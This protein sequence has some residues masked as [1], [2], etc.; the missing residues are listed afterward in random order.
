MVQK[1]S[2]MSKICLPILY[3]DSYTIFGDFCPKPF[4]L[5]LFLIPTF[6]C[7]ISNASGFGSTKSPVQFFFNSKNKV[8]EKVSPS[9][10]PA[11]IKNPSFIL[12]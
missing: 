6:I 9:K 2:K 12:F 11:S 10:A 1:G 8:L 4:G 7:K 5:Y 3:S